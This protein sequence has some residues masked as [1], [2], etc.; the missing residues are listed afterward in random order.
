[1]IRLRFFPGTLRTRM[2]LAFSALLVCATLVALF[3]SAA[4]LA[5]TQ[6]NAQRELARSLIGQL[7]PAVQQLA[8]RPGLPG[9]RMNPALARTLQDITHNPAIGSVRI[10][11]AAGR[12]LYQH[13]QDLEPASRL[14]RLLTRKYRVQRL[15]AME[16][17]YPGGHGG[18]AEIALSYRPLNAGLQ[19]LVVQSG[20]FLGALLLLIIAMTYTLLARFTAPLKP[21]T[22]MAREVSRG[23]WSPKVA[24]I[25]SGSSEIRELNRA[26]AAGS[27]SMQRHVQ[28]L[29]ETRELLAHSE[30][31][32][33]KLI[34][35]MHEILFEL[36]QDGNVSFLNPAWEQLT[37]FSVGEA[38]GRPFTGFLTEKETAQLFAPN[39]LAAL[40][41]KRCE[42]GLRTAGGKPLWMRLDASAQHDQA[43][44]F[45]GVIGTLGDITRSVELNQLLT[46][47][48]EDLYRLSVT[49]PLTGLYNRRH[50]DTQLEAILADQLSHGQSVCLL[51]VDVDGFKFINDTYGHPA[52]DEALR[53]IAGL[54]RARARPH[55][56]IARLAGDEFALVLKNASLYGATEIANALHDAIHAT[57]IGL[58][59]GHVQLQCSIGVAAAPVHGSSAQELVSAADVALYHAKRRGRNRVEVL[60]PDISKALMSIFSQ[61]FQLRN[62]L[63]QGNLMPAFQPI[64]DIRTGE[65][66]AYEALARM[67]HNGTL[68]MAADFISV[69]EE[70]G[71]T[72]EI[73]LHIIEQSLR[74]APLGYGLFLNID[75]SSF[76][77]RAFA[78]ELGELVGPGCR[79]GRSITIE[80][81]E[82][83]NVV[84]TDAL[85]A[86]IEY[87]RSLGCKLAL[88]DFGSGYSTYHFLNLFRPDYLKIEGTFVRRMLEHESDHKIVQHIHDL[89]RSFG[90]Q[91]IAESVE[92][93]ATREALLRLGIHS[94]QGRHLGSPRLS[95]E[96]LSSPH[97]THSPA[98]P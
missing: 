57:R 53:S 67:R 69:A 17:S 93:E 78:R 47:T 94:A 24:L 82:R 26:F 61:G 65:P 85:I 84:I 8:T 62:A 75:P 64:C 27:A 55:D 63:E 87:L 91:T 60:S 22:E 81:T 71:L 49:D 70:L 11:D 4:R 30:H 46:R 79:N 50:F 3:H 44:R 10:V 59:V 83:E 1:M 20:L 9:Q 12:T 28:S 58:P 42:T 33:R 36:D 45:T 15:V 66:I 14:T 88:D 90:A 98:T 2:V 16:F 21:L 37:G 34:N 43:G 73:D 25:E 56:Y 74:L 52:G 31:R 86:D 97:L 92:N 96:H 6:L 23:N 95:G 72:R 48:Q 89:A 40:Q 80:I 32:L 13:A 29:E 76:S 77:D 68:I 51:M 35:G 18:R 41:A 7:E 5:Q 19:E 54:L 39:Q 38:L